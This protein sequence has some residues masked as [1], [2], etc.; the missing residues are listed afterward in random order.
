VQIPAPPSPPLAIDVDGRFESWA[1]VQ[2][3][4]RHHKG[5]TM[6]R[7]HRG[8][9]KTFYEN[10][11]GRNDFIV[12]KVT[13]D[14]ENLYFYVETAGP[15]TEPAG[16]GWMTLWVDID[17]NKSTGWE[18]YDFAV[19]HKRPDGNEAALERSERGWNW[20]EIGQVAFRVQ[21]SRLEMR[22]PRTLVGL[23][24]NAP[25]DFEFKWTDNVPASGD[26]LDFY[27]YGD[28]APSGRFNY[29]YHAP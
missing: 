3:E 10:D 16:D 21:G 29:R 5:S 24:A 2:P 15:V 7:N 28:V 22:V 18:G 20:S 4:F 6:H 13:R 26:I 19:N 27:L 11:S 12:A 23:E 17:R 9:G 14:A 8:Y 1:E 25:L